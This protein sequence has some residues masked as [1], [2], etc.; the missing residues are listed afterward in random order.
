MKKTIVFDFDGVIHTYSSG[1]KGVDI[2]PDPVNPD[3]VEVIDK[4]RADG[5]EV[6]VVSTR[7]A[8]NAGMQAVLKYL[9][10]HGVIVD[11]VMATKPPALVYVDD[12]AVCYRP[13]VDLYGKIVN[14][15]TWRDTIEGEL[16]DAVDSLA[17]Q[18]LKAER[19]AMFR[20]FDVR[21]W[22]NMTEYAREGRRIQARYLLSRYE[23][24]AK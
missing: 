11:D 7:C 14:F 1:W 24:T 2:I 22:D 4:L 13:E 9:A 3:V 19:E 8:D 5:Y 17:F 10:D 20:S 6:I 12:R 21:A 16:V 23:I 15:K 18:L